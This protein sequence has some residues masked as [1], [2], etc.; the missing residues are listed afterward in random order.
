MGHQG[1]V[2]MRKREHSRRELV[3]KLQEQLNHTDQEATRT[4]GGYFM[5][6]ELESREATFNQ[7]MEAFQDDSISR[8]ALY[9]MG[10]VGKKTLAKQ[11]GKRVK[12]LNMFNLVVAVLVTS[13]PNVKQM[14]GDIAK[15]L[16]LR[17][18]GE[19]S[20]LASR[21]A[22]ISVGLR[23][24]GRVLVILYDVANKF[25]L[26][27]IGIGI[28]NDGSSEMV[29]KCKVL[30]TTSNRQVGYL[31]GCQCSLH[32][33]LLT[34]EEA[35]N[36]LRKH[37][38]VDVD[39]SQANLTSIA[40]DVAKHCQGLP[41][42]ISV[43]GYIL[44][45]K[46]VEKWKEVLESL[47]SKKWK[48]LVWKDDSSNFILWLIQLNYNA[49]SN[50]ARK[51]FLICGLF[52]ADYEILIEELCCYA[53]RLGLCCKNEVIAAVDGLMDSCL[54]RHSEKSKDHV[55][56][57]WLCCDI[58]NRIVYEENPTYRDIIYEYKHKL[59]F[60][61]DFQWHEELDRVLHRLFGVT[62]DPTCSTSNTASYAGQHCNLQVVQS[63][64]DA[65]AATIPK[66]S[67][68]L[69]DFYGLCRVDRSF[70]HL[71]KEACHKNPNLIE[72]QRKHSEM[73]RQSAFDSLGR[74]L[75]LLHNVRIRDWI[76]H[77]QELEMFWE[78]AKLMKFDLEWLSPTMQ[79]VLSS[80]DLA[81]IEALREEEKYWNEE[82]DKLREQLK[83]VEDKAAVIRTEISLAESKL[84]GFAIGYGSEA[85]VV[86]RFTPWRKIFQFR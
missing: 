19:E 31:M 30:L 32:L 80:A 40:K 50:I 21:K 12:D 10:G 66:P 73:L 7:I 86:S 79:R 42:A 23:N 61:E 52:P 36:S 60:K 20:D 49:L 34:E 43:I 1:H 76:Y 55:I 14:Q 84:E 27:D 85:R 62:D 26:Q 16:G 65:K 83:I 57:H 11:L 63:Y 18:E 54:L 70:L 2:L 37:A 69:V 39:G 35:W 47:Q 74:L 71:L 81:R 46:G 5:Q 44:R 8:V 64:Y 33:F 9:G 29:S 58:V 77:K 82:A 75:F 17:L 56:M 72:C 38:S 68:K 41:F 4:D 78:Q 67:G 13:P 48:G 25:D 15:Q 59:E 51:V 3:R 53:I 6:F 22:Q 45:G 28:P 24:K